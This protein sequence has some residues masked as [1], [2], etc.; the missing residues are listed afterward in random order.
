MSSARRGV[1][2]SPTAP[3]RPSSTR[4]SVSRPRRSSEA[5]GSCS[6]SRTSRY[7]WS[8][9]VP[10]LCPSR[11]SRAAALDRLDDV[12]GQRRA[13]GRLGDQPQLGKGEGRPS[14]QRVEHAVGCRRRGAQVD[15]G[16]RGSCQ[17]PGR[18][19][20]SQSLWPVRGGVNP[21]GTRTRVGSLAPDRAAGSRRHRVPA[22][23]VDDRVLE[24]GDLVHVP[25]QGV[26]RGVVLGGGGAQVGGPLADPLAHRVGG[27]AGP[28]DALGLGHQQVG[29]PAQVDG[30]LPQLVG[31]LAHHVRVAVHRHFLVA[32]WVRW[33]RRPPTRR[34]WPETPVTHPL[35]RAL[36]QSEG[37][38]WCGSRSSGPLWARSC[39]RSASPASAPS[40]PRPAPTD[41]GQA[42]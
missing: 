19:T 42:A 34:G 6:E 25:V 30:L 37:V 8:S 1:A 3:T 35:C 41:P 18:D 40:A 23:D 5:C 32:A 22:L 26:G 9:T 13:A 38:R 2:S 11:S 36:S 20:A 29:E 14:G 24:R 10:R 12:E 28:A 4:P 21:G 15:G 16:Q 27:P 7:P 39:Q 33:C 31:P 17:S